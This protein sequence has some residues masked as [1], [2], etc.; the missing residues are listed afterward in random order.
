MAAVKDALIASAEALA[1]ARG[2]D[3]WAA[4]D[5]ILSGEVELQHT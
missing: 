5:L 3:F 4:Q 2:I 1:A